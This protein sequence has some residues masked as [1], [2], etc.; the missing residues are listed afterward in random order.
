[1]PK[2][3]IIKSLYRLYITN[4][5]SNIFFCKQKSYCSRRKRQV[6]ITERHQNL[7]NNEVFT[8]TLTEINAGANS[9]VDFYKIQI[10]KRN[11]S[12]I[13]NTWVKQEKLQIARLIL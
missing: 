2:N 5:V 6:Q 8:N 11:C 13:D 1:M 10:D 9:V 4:G 3:T 12:L 7:D